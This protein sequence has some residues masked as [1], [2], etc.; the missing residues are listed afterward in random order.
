MAEEVDPILQHRENKL[1]LPGVAIP[2]DIRVTLDTA[3]ALHK[4]EM[5][6]L[7][8]PSH[9][10]R[11]ICQQLKPHLPAH[12][13]LVHVAKGIEVDTDARMSEVVHEELDRDV[14]VLSGPSHAEE[15]GR[16][17]PTAV[18]VAGDGADRV[19]AAFMNERFQIGRAHV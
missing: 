13:I 2:E 19:Q 7:A 11:P 18:V 5:V 1:F 10:M 4:P 17:V 8:V 12:A 9:G 6:V 15:V 3:A 14:V 16:G